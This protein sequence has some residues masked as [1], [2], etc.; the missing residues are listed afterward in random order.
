MLE[1]A[2]E[3]LEKY[4]SG[5]RAAVFVSGGG[6]SMCLLHLCAGRIPH[7]FFVVTV[8]HGIRPEAADEARFVRDECARLGVECLVYKADVPALAAAEGDGLETAGRRYRRELMRALIDGGQADVVLTAHHADD[9]AETVLMHALRGAGVGGLIGMRVRDGYVVRPLIGTRRAE[10]AAYNAA[11]SVPYVT[12]PSNADSRYTR[13]F[14]RNEVMPLL[15]SR[16]D[17]AGALN[18]LAAAA[19]ADEA[20]IRA[21]MKEDCIRAADGGIT[22]TDGAFSA[23]A[24]AP[25]YVFEAMRRLGADDYDSTAAARAIDLYAGRT[26]RRAPMSCGIEAVREAS[27]VT[28]YRPAP[29]EYRETPFAGPGPYPA[30]GLEVRPCPPVPEKGR[31][32]FDPGAVPDGAVLR[33]RREGDVF[34]PFGSGRK[35]LKEYLIDKKIPVRIRDKLPLLCYNEE[36]LVVCG[37][38][39]SDRVRLRDGGKAAEIVFTGEI[40]WKS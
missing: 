13:N 32:R 1:Q 39:I 10:I 2:K 34:R 29:A 3:I 20:Y 8:D 33:Y 30:F 19:A 21:Q 36:V 38:E 18:R 26:G 35:K 31:Q 12:D 28:L 24:L 9:N 4:V 11:F 37:L 25:R 23:D 16:F 40:P 15:N 17:A 7:G 22:L 27:G 14:I 6:D 5:K